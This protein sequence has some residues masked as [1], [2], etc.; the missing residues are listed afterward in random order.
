MLDLPLFITYKA[1]SLFPCHWI[2]GLYAYNPMLT[3]NLI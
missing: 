1:I 2:K 3:S